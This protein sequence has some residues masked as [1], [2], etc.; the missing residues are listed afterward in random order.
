[1]LIFAHFRP[2]PEDRGGGDLGFRLGDLQRQD[3]DPDGRWGRVERAGGDWGPANW[4]LEPLKFS[5][6]E[7]SCVKLGETS[8]SDSLAQ[9]PENPC[10]NSNM[11]C[12][13]LED[14]FPFETCWFKLPR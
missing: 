3:R 2:G 12:G 6:L 11:G 14:H 1:M 9:K 7:R 13:N 5:S 10:G 4:G 8:T